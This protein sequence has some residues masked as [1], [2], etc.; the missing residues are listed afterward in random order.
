MK[1][2]GI[3]NRRIYID[4][5]SEKMNDIV[6][7]F[8][9]NDTLSKLE[10]DEKLYLFEYFRRLYKRK[11]LVLKMNEMRAG[12]EIKTDIHTFLDDVV[13]RL[14][15][16]LARHELEPLSGHSYKQYR[17]TRNTSVGVQY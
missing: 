13:E 5:V 12:F 11:A 14:E 1:Q 2:I 15:Q 10:I 3:H 7:F 4:K 16:S 9:D 17:P 6:S 8:N